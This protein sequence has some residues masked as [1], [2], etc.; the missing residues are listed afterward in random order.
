MAKSSNYEILA[1]AKLVRGFDKELLLDLH[2]GYFTEH[3]R[4]I[5]K[6]ILNH[7]STHHRLPT[8]DVLRTIVTDKAPKDIIPIVNG[9]LTSVEKVDF[10]L[11]DNK[12]IT[13]GLKDKLLLTVLDDNIKD[14][15]TKAMQRDVDGVRGALSKVVQEVALQKVTPLNVEDAIEQEDLAKIIP[16]CIDGLDEHITGM[17]G[18]TLIG[19][20]SGSG[21]SVLLMEA[22]IEQFIA[23]HNVLFISLE[24]SAKIFGNRLKAYLTGIDFSRINRDGMLDKTT[25]QS[26]NLLTPEE[27]ATIKE[28]TKEF[29]NRPNRFRIITNPL[30]SEELLQLIAVDKSLYDIDV[31]YVDYLNLIGAPKGSSG[32]GWRN[33]SE[34]AKNLHRLS[35]SH[36][37][38][39]VSAVQINLTKAP[40]NGGLP[41]VEVRGSQELLFSSTLFLFI[42]KPDTADEDQKD[43]IILYVMKNRNGPTGAHLMEK[44]FSTMRISYVMPL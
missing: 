29:F 15:T 36:G 44:S 1:I 13:T 32:E 21:K 24:L 40:K 33:L 18:L 4:P 8:L 31:V 39:T 7:F 16:T 30:D 5:F 11:V 28:A 14:L 20:S 12:E 17:A 41:T 34:L 43:S 9:V 6:L 23:G 25:G 27:R 26:L 10:T 2:Q 37:I 3:N 38:I 35:T 22:A 42:Y 19:G